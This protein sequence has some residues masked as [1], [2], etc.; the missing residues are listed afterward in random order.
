MN[1]S[2]LALFILFSAQSFASTL[3]AREAM[4]VPANST[5]IP[6]LDSK[7]EATQDQMNDEKEPSHWASATCQLAY[8][9]SSNPR[10]IAKGAELQISNISES[11]TVE[12]AK[13]YFQELNRYS[14]DQF[15]QMAKGN[16]MT[17][18]L[19]GTVQSVDDV[20]MALAD[21][22]GFSQE[23]AKQLLPTQIEFQLTK[24]SAVLKCLVLKKY[25]FVPNNESKISDSSASDL[26]IQLMS[27]YG[28][29]S[30]IEAF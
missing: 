12:T 9:A 24:N 7:S 6:V 2:L 19:P 28:K 26:L 5:S 3:T 23:Q 27:K 15:R 30:P 22:D 10:L 11:Q 21:V 20:A 8:A 14:I 4:M 13:N 25:Y 16:G 1:K 29:L 17:S 18:N